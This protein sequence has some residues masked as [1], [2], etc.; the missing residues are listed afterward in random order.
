MGQSC[1]ARKVLV[2]IVSTEASAREEGKK[3]REAAQQTQRHR[4]PPGLKPGRRQS[5]CVP[6]SLNPHN[7]SRD[8]HHQPHFTEMESRLRIREVP[9]PKVTGR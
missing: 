9:W 5:L 4:R 2:I 6:I 8:R 3:R 7:R 1:K